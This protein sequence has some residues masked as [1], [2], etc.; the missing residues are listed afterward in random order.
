M[1][2]KTKLLYT[3][4]ALPLI[5][6][7]TSERALRHPLSNQILKPRV[8][9]SGL[10]NN[11]CEE[12]D[13][14]GKCTKEGIKEYSFDD[15]TFRDSVNKLGFICNVG[16]RRFKICLDKP[17]LCRFSYIKK[18]ALFWKKTKM[19]EEYIPSLNYQYLLDANTKCFSK[20]V[21]PFD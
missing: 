16:G 2:S 7:Q 4:L 10:T 11:A 13:S 15:Q 12:K 1:R 14:T 5:S 9:H 8:G 18:G 3:L 17:G 6:C 21:Y 19:N 20:E